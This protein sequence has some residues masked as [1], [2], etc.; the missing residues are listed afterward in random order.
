MKYFFK[1]RTL[2]RKLNDYAPY[3][4]ESYLK[5]IE[6]DS[7]ELAGTSIVHINTAASSGGV[8][9]MLKSQIPI[10]RSVGLRSEWLVMRGPES[11][12]EITKK[13]H[14]LLQGKKD[15]ITEEEKGLY[16]LQSHHVAEELTAYLQTLGRTIVVFHDPQPLPLLNYFPAH[17]PTILRLHPDL[18]TP[19]KDVLN[20]LKPLIMRT[21]RV[22][23]SDDSYR[24]R[25]YPKKNTLLS[26]PALDP[27]NKKN[28]ALSRAEARKI[29]ADGGIDATR[30]IVSQISR[31]DPWKD[32]LGVIEAYRLA[33]KKVSGLQLVMMGLI[34]A[35]D[36]PEA[37]G[38]YASV[39][40]EAE[41]DPDIYLFG[42]KTPPAGYSNDIFVS[43]LQSGSEIVLQKST[44]EGFG[45]ALTEAMWKS[46]AVIGG[47]VTG[48]RHQ[49]VN[50][51]N[52]YRIRSIRECA[53]RMVKLLQN[54]PLRASLGQAA[55]RTV[56]KKF[57]MPR[58]ISDHVKLYRSLTQGKK[59]MQ[60][61]VPGPRL[62][63]SVIASSRTPKLTGQK[64]QAQSKLLEQR[65]VSEQRK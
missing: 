6:A 22:I 62:P 56:Q 24:P 50:A 52:G 61:A 17:I 21:G 5:G 9:E 1:P 64:L 44:R 31:F 49:I 47:D 18:S 37:K 40:A 8:A 16:L 45:L 19:D 13:M 48:I 53:D 12:F 42:E 33:R 34:V 58:L 7:A 55:K 43:A 29:L 11:F 46:A 51:K 63:S 2:T 23:V 32:P 4:S 54:E 27:L 41:S 39:V 25:Y 36:D 15:S 35:E 59:A 38:L 30:P 26:F 65:K 10:E 14:N 28:V 3:V 60:Y 20:F 57:L